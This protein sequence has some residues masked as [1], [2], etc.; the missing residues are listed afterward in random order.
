MALCEA[1]PAP[2]AL[3]ETTTSDVALQE[4]SLVPNDVSVSLSEWQGLPTAEAI[5]DA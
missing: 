4:E 2:V 3:T 5:P 1:L